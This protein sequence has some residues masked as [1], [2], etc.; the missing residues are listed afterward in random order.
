[1]TVSTVTCG[2]LG[3]ANRSRAVALLRR[4][5]DT[6]EQEPEAAVE[7]LLSNLLSVSVW[8]TEAAAPLLPEPP[9][10]PWPWQAFRTVSHPG[11]TSTSTALAPWQAQ[12][13]G[14]T[15]SCGSALAVTTKPDESNHE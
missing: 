10:A 5:A 6:L 11:P 8:L 7:L 15:T 13:Y 9:R 3:A 4:A 2:E 1:M 12:V 14:V